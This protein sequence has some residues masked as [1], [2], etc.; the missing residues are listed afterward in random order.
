MIKA[1]EKA[2]VNEQGQLSRGGWAQT[3]QGFEVQLRR[4]TLIISAMRT[5][6]GYQWG[7]ALI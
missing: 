3:P 6:G 1:E 5:T 2:S 4:L 7:V